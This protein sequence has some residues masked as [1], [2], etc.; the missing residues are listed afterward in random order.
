MKILD[1]KS[2]AKKILDDIKNELINSYDKPRLDIFLI[3]NNS[4]SEKYVS[5]KMNAAT[6]IGI[7]TI[8]H[9][10]PED[11]NEISILSE[12]N[13]LNQNPD[14]NGIMVQLPLPTTFNSQNIL[15]KI[16]VTKDV[17]GLNAYNLGKMFA[18]HDD[19]LLS[20]TTKAISKI[21]SEYGIDVKGKD[22]VVVGSS[23][24]VGLP[25]T[26]LFLN[27]GSTVT[28]CNENTVDLDEKISQAD[29]IVSAT[30]TPGLIN[31]RNVKV[32]AVVI[33]VGFTLIDGKIF[34]D[35]DMSK[36]T[37]IASSITPVPGGVGPVTVAC[38]LENT[39]IAWKN[40]NA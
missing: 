21:L 4:A 35:A 31:D 10:Y 36:L 40:Q 5:L 30:G 12:I 20:A 22:V 24:Q 33:D 29:I 25:T 27:L 39:L 9:K 37:Y 18:N 23:V 3:G 11:V 14:V 28:I 16:D 38:L 34:G 2:L 32:G 19:T 6:E 17:D 13:D 15:N 8:L 1:G 26:A 7:N